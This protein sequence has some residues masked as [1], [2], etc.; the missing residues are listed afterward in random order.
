MRVKIGNRIYDAREEPILIVLSQ[1]EK[2]QISNMHPDATRYMQYPKSYFNTDE[3]ALRWGDI[4]NL[5]NF[6]NKSEHG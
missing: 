4:S 6:F 2:E 3:E 1:E 5:L